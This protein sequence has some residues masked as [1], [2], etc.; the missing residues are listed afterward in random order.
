V[1]LVRLILLRLKRYSNP[2]RRR[3]RRREEE[4]EQHYPQNSHTPQHE[5][6]ETNTFVD[7][8]LDEALGGQGFLRPHPLIQRPEPPR[9]LSRRVDIVRLRFARKM[10]AARR[11]VVLVSCCGG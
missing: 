8:E 7:H 10:L 1:L 11:V 3:S 9:E 2:C 5:I 4:E 6:H